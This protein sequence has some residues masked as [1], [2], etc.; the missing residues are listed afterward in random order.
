[1]AESNSSSNCVTEGNAKGSLCESRKLPWKGQK[2]YFALIQTKKQ[3]QIPKQDGL[4][5]IILQKT[6]L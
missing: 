3:A 2:L 1:M 6:A 4:S 5:S